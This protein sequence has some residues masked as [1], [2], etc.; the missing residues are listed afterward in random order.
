MNSHR[1]LPGVGTHNEQIFVVGG[2]ND[3]WEAQPMVESY[4]PALNRNVF[5]ITEFIYIFIHLLLIRYHIL[6]ALWE[7]ISVMIS[8]KADLTHQGLSKIMSQICAL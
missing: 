1:H 3:N 2:T 7:I 8:I 6:K 5:M 4:D